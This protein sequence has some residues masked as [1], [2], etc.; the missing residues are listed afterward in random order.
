MSLDKLKLHMALDYWYGLHGTI[1]ADL[2]TL[3]LIAARA[4]VSGVAMSFG[5]IADGGPA[6]AIGE[7]DA[8]EV[9]KLGAD[10]VIAGTR[11]KEAVAVYERA[12]ELV[13]RQR[14]LAAAR[15]MGVKIPPDET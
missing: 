9:Q 4:T 15:T 13:M 2:K 3:R 7:Q 10:L 12:E 1:S 8:K 11:L 14:T 5:G 6:G